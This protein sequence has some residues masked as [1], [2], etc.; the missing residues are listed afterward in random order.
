MSKKYKNMCT[1]DACLLKSKY[2]YPS[3]IYL[4]K[5]VPNIFF[6]TLRVV[7]NLLNNC[8]VFNFKF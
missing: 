5:T 3:P 4:T 2:N 7:N 8:N 1:S 6:G